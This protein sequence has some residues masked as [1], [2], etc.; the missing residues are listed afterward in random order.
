MKDEKNISNELE[1]NIEAASEENAGK[2]Y[3]DTNEQNKKEEKNALNKKKI[4]IPIVLTIIIIGCIVGLLF[5]IIL[6]NK[7]EDND[8]KSKKT[9]S[10]TTTELVI[11][12][13]L[14]EGFKVMDSEVLDKYDEGYYSLSWDCKEMNEKLFSFK[15]D[16]KNINNIEDIDYIK[17]ENNKLMWN[18]DNKWIYDNDIKEDIDFINAESADDSSPYHQFLIQTKS[19]NIYIIQIPNDYEIEEEKVF[20]IKTS[21]YNR[22]TRE[23]ISTDKKITNVIPIGYCVEGGC[24]L[25][26][27]V[28]AEGKIYLLEDK[29]ISLDE[30]KKNLN[31]ISFG[32]YSE[33]FDTFVEVNGYGE[34]NVLNSDGEKIK[35]KYYAIYM[36]DYYADDRSNYPD[37]HILVSEDNN[38]Y[39]FKATE[40]KFFDNKTTGLKPLKGKFV[41]INDKEQIELSDGTI[42]G[43]PTEE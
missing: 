24:I 23:K 28:E 4:V 16:N 6:M 40:N 21:E 9:T 34:S 5:V 12:N 11:E 18:V 29:L 41:R 36:Q 42:I 37:L 35:I 25:E 15:I 17:I 33:D 3:E 13:K 32:Y 26:Y 10:S 19:K 30:Y 22:I 31:L 1:N 39:S 7:S 38:V 14:P 2:I 43:Y 27:F 8:N 20:T